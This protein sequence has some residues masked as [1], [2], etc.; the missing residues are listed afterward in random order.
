V[1]PDVGFIIPWLV[2]LAAYLPLETSITPPINPGV[3]LM[4]GFNL[5]SAPLICRWTEARISRRM[6]KERVQRICLSK[7][8]AEFFFRFLCGSLC[9]WAAAFLL[10]VVYSGGLP[11]IWAL[12]GDSRTYA[13]FGIPSVG[14]L[15]IML[16]SFSAS[17]S[18]FMFHATRRKIYLFFWFVLL[19]FCVAEVSR[20][21]VFVLM[22]QSVA[23]FMLLQRIGL[24]QALWGVVAMLFLAGAFVVLG[25][26]RDIKMNASD[27]QIDALGGV[28][29]GIYW[30]WSYLVSPL[31]NVN[32][33]ASLGIQPVF[34]PANTLGAIVPS[35]IGVPLGLRAT[36]YPIP[37][38]TSSLNAT[39][40]YAP[41]MA[42]FGLL[43]AA[44]LMSALQIFASYAY[45]MARRG[46]L[47]Y[48]IFYPALFG[49]LALSIFY[50]YIG[51]LQ[52]LLIP[53]MVVWLRR[54]YRRRAVPA[55]PMG[56]PGAPTG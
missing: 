25:S 4:L 41:L 11:I 8:T 20:S 31:G 17:F 37:L 34:W 51:S 30:A 19:V 27:F 2:V 35:F 33:A 23:A 45:G 36:E 29:V 44:M 16:R 55:P 9:I 40:M 56:A 52:V 12:T 32:Y 7:A 15:T 3:A 42:D 24:R 49:C 5:L 43:G 50:N 1:R 48:V 39:S 26:L 6:G 13:D 54:F 38:I 14:G 10:S 47:L 18:I 21:A 28:P 22:A 53:A 46:D